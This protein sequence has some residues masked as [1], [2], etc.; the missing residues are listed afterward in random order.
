MAISSV[1]QTVLEITMAHRNASKFS[2]SFIHLSKQC[3]PRS[4]KQSEPSLFTLVSIHLII[5]LS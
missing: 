4:N 5:N 2:D 1:I 3:R